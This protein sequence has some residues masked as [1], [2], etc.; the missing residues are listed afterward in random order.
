M[1]K[2]KLKFKDLSYQP[3]EESPVTIHN[4]K[5][6]LKNLSESK[7]SIDKT[8]PQSLNLRTD[9]NYIPISS[10]TPKFNMIY[11]KYISNQGNIVYPDIRTLISN[12]QGDKIKSFNKKEA[13]HEEI[14][15]EIKKNRILHDLLKIK[16]TSTINKNFFSSDKN[17]TTF[18]K[19]NRANILDTFNTYALNGKLTSRKKW[20]NVGDYLIYKSL[21]V[22][23]MFQKKINKKKEKSFKLYTQDDIK[24][25]DESKYNNKTEND[26]F[27]IK[28]KNKSINDMRRFKLIKK[29]EEMEQKEKSSNKNNKMKISNAWK[30]GHKKLNLFCDNV[31]NDSQRLQNK[32]KMTLERFNQNWLKYKK[33]QEFKYPETQ[34][35][36]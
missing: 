35:N 10:L 28:I 33:L 26:G 15:E 6:T 19:E 25:I 31:S 29:L 14:G 22:K 3:K 7:D 23:K 8:I 13:I 27:N 5:I 30:Y 12:F 20:K 36:D 1:S 11:N 2:I 34:C 16:K 17:K 32:G 9:P 21:D 24:I 18:L 4:N